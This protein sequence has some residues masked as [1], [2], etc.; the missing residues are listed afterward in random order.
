[1][2]PCDQKAADNMFH[3]MIVWVNAETGD[4]FGKT[5][6][7]CDDHPY[8]EVINWTNKGVCIMSIISDLLD[9]GSGRIDVDNLC[10]NVYDISNY[11]ECRRNEV[12]LDDLVMTASLEHGHIRIE[13]DDVGTNHAH[14]SSV[15][16]TRG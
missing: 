13:C 16:F 1:M 11:S 15:M 10:V 2:D 4:E 6:V 14:L 5:F 12:S 7:E 8:D 3:I 9:E